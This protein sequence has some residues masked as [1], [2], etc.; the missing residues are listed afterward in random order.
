MPSCWISN[1]GCPLI[2]HLYDGV[3]SPTRTVDL[4]SHNCEPPHLNGFQTLWA[5]LA[6]DPGFTQWLPLGW[7]GAA[8][9][10]IG[11]RSERTKWYFYLALGHGPCQASG[12]VQLGQHV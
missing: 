1:Y 7:T 3:G 8:T 4:P 11:I 5:I 12:G 9:L 10:I 6:F 2:G